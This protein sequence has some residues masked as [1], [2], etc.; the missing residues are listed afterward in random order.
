MIAILDYGMGNLRSVEK[1]FEFLGFSACVTDDKKVLSNASHI[2]LPGVGAISD[3]VARLAARGL[4]E[5]IMRQI[6]TGKP[7]LGICL[8]MQLLLESSSENGQYKCLGVIPGR[9]EPFELKD[10]SLKIPHMGWNDIQPKDSPLFLGL[11]A[12]AYMYFVHSYH[13]VEVPEENRLADCNY[14]YRFTC[15]V[16][17]GN[18]FGLQFHPEKSGD[19]GLKILKNFGGLQ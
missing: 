15:G 18:V 11:S 12:P 9:V 3:A 7:F 19:E 16:T 10:R 2:V 5:E 4:D 14:G 1:A 8:G 13:A 17:K 6:E